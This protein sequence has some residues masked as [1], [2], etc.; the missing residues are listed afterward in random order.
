[1]GKEPFGDAVTE[2]NRMYVYHNG[3]TNDNYVCFHPKAAANRVLTGGTSVNLKCMDLTSVTINNYGES[4]CAIP[5]AGWSSTTVSA[6]NANLI[7]VP[8][9]T[10]Q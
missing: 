8:E 3:T 1:M 10:I 5:V 2:E 6:T 9:G 7:C 4:N